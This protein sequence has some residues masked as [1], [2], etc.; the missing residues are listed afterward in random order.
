MHSCKG[1]IYREAQKKIYVYLQPARPGPERATS[2]FALTRPSS[3]LGFK[4]FFFF[5][6]VLAE[7]EEEG[8]GYNRALKMGIQKKKF[9]CVH[10]GSR[11]WSKGEKE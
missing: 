2:S 4:I 9:T 10:M 3:L 1:S 7:E 5:Y 8:G 6:F 11:N